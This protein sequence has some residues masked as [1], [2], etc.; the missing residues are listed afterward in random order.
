MTLRRLLALTSSERVRSW[1]QRMDPGCSAPVGPHDN[2]EIKFSFVFWTFM[3]PVLLTACPGW[4]HSQ[5]R[6]MWTGEESGGRAKSR[7]PDLVKCRRVMRVRSKL[8]ISPFLL[9]F[10]ILR[11]V[12]F[13]YP[14]HVVGRKYI[15]LSQMFEFSFY[16]FYWWLSFYI[17]SIRLLLSAR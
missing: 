15:F 10:K 6:D 11:H 14:K 13:S 1:I 9:P 7:A 12:V 16:I 5:K 3:L 17:E 8:I 4:C 2:C